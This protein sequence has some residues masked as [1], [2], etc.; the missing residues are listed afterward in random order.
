LSHVTISETDTIIIGGG[1]AGLAVAG[2]LTR[3]GRNVLL[4]EA[5][6]RLGGRI[7]TH[8]EPSL[9]G[10]VEL[11]AEFV[12]GKPPQ[13]FDLIHAAGLDVVEGADRRLISEDGALRPL[14][15]F[16]DIIEA[17]DSQIPAGFD[18][19]YQ[20]FLQTANA[21]AFQKQIAKSYVEGFNAARADLIST[22][23]LKFEEDAAEKIEA[24]KQFRITR[25]YASIVEHLARRLPPES[26]RT[27]CVV[28]A[29]RWRKGHVEIDATA[30]GESLHFSGRRA[31]VTLPLGVLRAAL[32]GEPDAIAFDPPLSSKR[33][34]TAHLEVGHVV[35]IVM[36]FRQKFW[37]DPDV[38][39]Q[40]ASF[41]FALCLEAEFP[42][43]WTQDPTPS[44]LLT[45]WAGGPAADKLIGRD[46]EQLRAAAF[47]SLS[48]TFHVN[49]D[50][51]RSLFVR[52]HFHDWA[53]DPFALGAYTYPKIGGLR[54]AKILAEP[55][56]DTLF[57]AGEATDITGFNGTVHGALA[58]AVRVS[59]QLL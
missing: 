29:V 4:L 55:I 14:D 38:V 56:H 7:L 5:R 47:A 26:I 57:F 21:S 13:L 20:E 28:R 49:V 33:E 11:G 41:G 59:Q 2:E 18:S 50:R 30:G 46:R 31:V 27:G 35:K 44:N 34:A 19:S 48:A 42:T 54:A 24:T 53:R 39:G 45:G 12:H 6:E 15:N 1:V 8:H 40:C 52:D 43:W 17:V 22:A 16:W 32:E 51:L 3:A 58:S 25:G 23:A 36:Q 37:D 10:P 9:G